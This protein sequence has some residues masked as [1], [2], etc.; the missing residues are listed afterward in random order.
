MKCEE[1]DVDFRN[2]VIQA[3]RQFQ[4][5][6]FDESFAL[7]RKAEKKLSQKHNG[8]IYFRLG[9][10]Y[11][12]GHG[13]IE[14]NV[15][16]AEN[17]FKLA[18]KHI[19]VSIAEGDP[20]AQCD[21]GYMYSFGCG[22]AQCKT[23]AAKYYKLAADSGL[24]RAQHN[25]AHMYDTGDGIVKDQSMAI[26][27]YKMAADRG[28][29]S[30]QYNLGYMYDAT[31]QESDA[32][33][34][35]EMAAGQGF[36]NAQ[37]NLGELLW[38]YNTTKKEKG[39]GIYY[40]QMAADQGDLD[41]H[42]RLGRIYEKGNYTKK[43]LTKSIYHYLAANKTKR[44][45]RIFTGV[46]GDDFKIHAIYYLFNMWPTSHYLVNEKCIEAMREIFFGFGTYFT[47]VFFRDSY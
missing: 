25:L 27:Y 45:A 7:Y 47:L 15:E 22:L 21:L 4:F 26:N 1:E 43:D 12:Y 24:A 18:L 10:L 39:I 6:H 13:K 28:D 17:Y 44:L 46:L 36:C 41:A 5:S 29:I 23:E 3:D 35:Y 34:F 30:A 38:R 32:I 37:F 40:Y 8:H 11:K 2:T 33:K 16:I 9:V 19:L 20:E 14:E 31:G 42:L